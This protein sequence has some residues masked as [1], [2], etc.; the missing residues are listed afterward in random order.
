M[1]IFYVMN[2]TNSETKGEAN[3][4]AWFTDRVAGLMPRLMYSVLQREKNDLAT[5]VLSLPQFGVLNF[6]CNNGVCTMHAVS[7]SLNMTPSNLTGI[8][9][10]LVAMGMV[11]R[12]NDDNDR[13]IV[14]AEATSKGVKALE[15]VMDEKRALMARFCEC[16]TPE[17]R[18][19][20]VGALSKLV[21]MLEKKD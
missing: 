16:L 4:V 19:V 20:Y 17:E 8:M 3:G 18:V 9:D 15:R 7:G 2:N 12:F 13:R 14:L 10:R 1:I 11:R 21:D 6:L 5:G